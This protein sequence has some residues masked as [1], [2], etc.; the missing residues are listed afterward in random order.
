MEVACNNCGEL[1][2]LKQWQIK[3]RSRKCAKCYREYS[4]RLRAKRKEAGLPH[5][6][7][8]YNRLPKVKEKLARI[9]RERSKVPEMA[10]KMKTRRITRDAIK[11]GILIKQ[12]CK[13]CG[14]E[15]VEAHHEDYGKPLEVIWLCRDHHHELHK[16]QRNKTK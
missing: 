13:V 6:Q 4:E 12:P 5:R 1:F 2:I 14:I 9:M 10:S 3:F 15:K 11:K 8:D 16:K 7:Y